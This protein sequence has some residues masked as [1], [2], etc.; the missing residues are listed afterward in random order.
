MLRRLVLQL[1]ESG[2]RRYDQ[3][4]DGGIRPLV[5]RQEQVKHGA[6]RRSSIGTA[7]RHSC[8]CSAGDGY[9]GLGDEHGSR[10]QIPKRHRA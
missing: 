2:T 8:R 5:A 1:A 4:G 3:R 7:D 10:A 9:Y 6:I